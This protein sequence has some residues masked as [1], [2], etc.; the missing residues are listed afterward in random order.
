MRY[1]ML[2]FTTP[3]VVL[4]LALTA[5]GA[6]QAETGSS[7]AQSKGVPS[8]QPPS[9]STS[10]VQPGGSAGGAKDKL[11]IKVQASAKA[12]AK[13]VTLTCEPA[14][15][16]HPD[17]SGACQT[18]AAAQAPFKAP[19]KSQTQICT[20][21]YGGPQVANVQGTWQ[22]KPVKAKFTRTDG[23]ELNRWKRLGPVLDKLI[24]TA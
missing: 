11:T 24:P 12:P 13:T 23:C 9:G 22:G 2:I 1:R 18:L 10:T 19:P 4:I 21:I 20:K 15:G 7:T 17:A 5:C 3:A 6:E 14:G 16:S 8:S